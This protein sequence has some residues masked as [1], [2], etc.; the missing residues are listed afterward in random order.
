MKIDHTIHAAFRHCFHNYGAEPTLLRHRDG[1]PIALG[2]RAEGNCKTKAKG[3]A[4]TWLGRHS[5]T[6][7]LAVGHS[8]WRRR[9]RTGQKSRT[10]SRTC[11]GRRA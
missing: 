1:R 5:T 8:L 3:K 2:P 10:L 9:S 4:R 7:S 11:P 6:A